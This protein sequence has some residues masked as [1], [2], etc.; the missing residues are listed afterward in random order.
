MIT[1]QSLDNLPPSVSQLSRQNVR[2][3]TSQNPMGLH[4]L[5]TGITLLL[6]FTTH[7]MKFREIHVM[8]IL[9]NTYTNTLGGQYVEFFNVETGGA[10]IYHCSFQGLNKCDL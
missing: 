6:P 8:T 5:V 9:R 1:Y 10:Y 2:A 7:L 3:S 4:G